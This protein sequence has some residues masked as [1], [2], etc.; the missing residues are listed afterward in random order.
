MVGKYKVRTDLAMENGE[1]Y[2]KD[3]VEISGVVIHKSYNQE[4]D[5]RTTVVKIESEHG[6]KMMEKP[7]GT[8]ITLEAPNMAVPD[9]GYHR[10]VSVELAG[11]LKKLLP[12][13][14]DSVLV[15]GLGNRNITPDALGPMA[16]EHVRITRHII[17]EYG[18]QALGEDQVPMISALV[19]GVMA[20]TGMDT[21]EIL[22]GVIAQTS[23]DVILIIDALAARSTKRLSCTIQLTDTGINPGSGVGNSR[24][25]LNEESLHI[26]VIGIGIPTV[27][28]AGTIVH[29][30]VSNLLETLEESE[31]D[32]FLSELIS[33]SLNG[34]CVTPKDIDETVERL[35]FTISEGINMALKRA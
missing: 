32:E 31:I 22:Q 19:P 3:N 8:Y 20:Q 14:L 5:I 13:N 11:H 18:E 29:D 17:R 26:P 23:P 12:P 9:E 16:I 1:K 7:I 25:G 27:I 34:M 15:V 28:D 21:M 24:C 30:A 10:E 2:E 4:K 35:S 33:P 6:A